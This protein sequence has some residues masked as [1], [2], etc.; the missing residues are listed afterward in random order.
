MEWFADRRAWEGLRSVGVVESV[1]EVN[2]VATTDRRYFLSSLTPD[3]QRLVRVTRAHWGIENRV[4]WVLYVQFGD[5]QCRARSGFA[6]EN[7]ATL[8]HLTLNMLRGEKS[9][10]L[11]IRAK[12][13]LAGWDRPYLL[14][15]L[16]IPATPS[17]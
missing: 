17:A 8:R 7:L 6:A 9:R 16:G 14:K 11:S 4:H 5:D 10:K 3:A 13:I 2:G 12:R 1:R 15:I